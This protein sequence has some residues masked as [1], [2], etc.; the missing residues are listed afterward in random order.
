MNKSGRFLVSTGA[1]GCRYLYLFTGHQTR[2]RHRAVLCLEPEPDEDGER[3]SIFTDDGAKP[4]SDDGLAYLLDW[5]EENVVP[6]PLAG[7]PTEG[8]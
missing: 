6:S 1:D 2:A 4:V 8:T 7:D 3:G 5:L